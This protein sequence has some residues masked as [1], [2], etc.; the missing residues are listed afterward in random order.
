MDTIYNFTGLYRFL[1]NFYPVNVK[2]KL[3]PD[4][5]FP[6]VEHGYQAEKSNDFKVQEYIARIDK[7]GIAKR[8]VS[9]NVKLSDDWGQYKFYVM[10]Y[11]L[12]EKFSQEDLQDRLLKTGD[13]FF[14]EGNEWHDNIWGD[15]RCT[16]CSDIEGRNELGRLL[17][18][19]R[20]TLRKENYGNL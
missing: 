17:M 8:W 12:R 3:Y 10:K 20:E 2:G 5:I 18:I 15:C 6:S 1:S 14:V 9:R 13:A 19:I 16:I 4:I 7:P 11:Y